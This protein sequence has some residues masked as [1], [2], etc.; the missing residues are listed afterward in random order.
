MPKS[1]VNVNFRFGLLIDNISCLE[2]LAKGISFSYLLNVL[3]RHTVIILLSGNVSLFPYW[4]PTVLNTAENTSR[5]AHGHAPAT[6]TP[7]RRE[8]GAEYQLLP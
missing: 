4:V 7:Y 2:A 5:L 1:P 6:L 8:K 3:L